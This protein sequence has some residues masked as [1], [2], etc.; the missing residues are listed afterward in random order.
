[1]N[2]VIRERMRTRLV[3]KER[4]WGTAM[5]CGELHVGTLEMED[6]L[7]SRQ[8]WR[9]TR[10]TLPQPERDAATGRNANFNLSSDFVRIV[11]LLGSLGFEVRA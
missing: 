2:C 1:M 3:V 7:T 5:F 11:E 6:L 4:E 10:M 9:L 8:F